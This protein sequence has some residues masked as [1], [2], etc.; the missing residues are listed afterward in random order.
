MAPGPVNLG[1]RI[2]NGIETGDAFS[3]EPPGTGHYCVISVVGT[4]FFTNLPSLTG[5]NWNTQEWIHNNGAA[6]WHNTDVAKSNR[7]LLKVYN[8][9]GT[10]ERFSFK[11]HCHNLPEGSVISLDCEDAEL[12]HP[13]KTSRDKITKAYHQVSTEAE[14]P[15][16]FEGELAVGFDI[17]GGKLPAGAWVD[18]HMDWILPHDHPCFLKALLQE[19]D[20]HAGM[21]KK[22]VRIPMGNFTFLGE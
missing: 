18:V 2:A 11:A 7:A 15:P 16:N 13:I 22:R 12:T 8:Q 3:F 10:A 21:L 20:P 6:G 1:D 9:D 19:D 5:G 4:E 17:P 14:L